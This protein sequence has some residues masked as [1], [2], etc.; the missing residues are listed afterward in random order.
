MAEVQVAGAVEGFLWGPHRQAGGQDLVLVLIAAGQV[1]AKSPDGG[2][3]AVAQPGEGQQVSASEFTLDVGERTVVATWTVVNCGQLSL[4]CAR[5]RWA[6]DVLVEAGMAG[7]PLSCWT[8]VSARTGCACRAFCA[9][10]PRRSSLEMPGLVSAPHA[11]QI[12][13]TPAEWCRLTGLAASRRPG[14]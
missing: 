4:A 1:E 10:H 2:R 5:S 3:S 13:L 11:R 9:D 7:M 14:R 12:S 6:S 8:G